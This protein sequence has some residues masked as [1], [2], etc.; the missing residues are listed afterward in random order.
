V[1]PG[2]LGPMNNTFVRCLFEWEADSG[3]L[4]CNV[5]ID[6]G[7]RN[8]FYSCSFHGSTTGV[9]DT[10]YIRIDDTYGLLV[11]V[12]LDSCFWPG[13]ISAPPYR[14][15]AI[16]QNGGNVYMVGN[17]AFNNMRNGWEYNAGGGRIMGSIQYQG[18]TNRWTGTGGLNRPVDVRQNPITLLLESDDVYAVQGA[19][20]GD[21]NPRFRLDKNGVLAWGDGTA[22][23]DLQIRRMGTGWGR[24]DGYLDMTGG[25]GILGA[26]EHKGMTAGFYNTAPVAKPTGVAVSA[27]GIHAALVALGLIGA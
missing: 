14:D 12:T 11:E 13:P 20:T 15:T 23:T 17:N 3:A 8:L 4:D 9:V 1:D 19:Q 5:D 25:T 10:P 22:A 18:V 21:V 7:W 2:S 26:L 6:S 27:A 24:V 16:E